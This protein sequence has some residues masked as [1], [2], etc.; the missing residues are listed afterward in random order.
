MWDRDSQMY[1]LSLKHSHS[2]SHSQFQ[3]HSVNTQRK[4]IRG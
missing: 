2:H 3:F 4:L 1:F